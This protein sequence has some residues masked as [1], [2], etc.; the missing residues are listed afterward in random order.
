MI[1]CPVVWPAYFVECFK[2]TEH[3]KTQYRGRVLCNPNS[4][5]SAAAVV[6]DARARDTIHM[7]QE[8]A[9]TASLIGDP[10]RSV[11]LLKLLSGKALPAGELAFAANVSPQTASGHLAKLIEGRL[12][13]MEPQGRHRYYR[14]AGDEVASAV[15]SLLAIMPSRRTGTGPAITPT[16]GT[17]PYARTCY[18]HLA[19]WLGVNLLDAMQAN[20]LLA[21]LGK[22][23]SVTDAGRAWLEELGVRVPSRPGPAVSQFARQC[24]DWTERRPHLA[25]TLGVSMY[26]RTV[27]LGWL[28]PITGT[29]AVRVTFQGK[30]ELSKRLGM[31][32]G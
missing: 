22:A 4:N 2:F 28:S 16:V 14:L 13:L 12:V 20:G 25:G 18:S 6:S 10:T 21:P 30:H 24:L 29:R 8:F 19:G 27:D 23:F 5:I 7:N 15:E 9:A 3:I 32:L 17:L 26:R 31:K 1:R 11:M